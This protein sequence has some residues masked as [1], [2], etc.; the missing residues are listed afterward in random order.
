VAK[1][2]LSLPNGAAWPVRLLIFDFVSATESLD[3][4][5]GVNQLLFAGEERMTVGANVNRYLFSGG[6]GF[7]PVSARARY[8]YIV[9]LGMHVLLQLFHLQNKHG[10]HCRLIRK[11]L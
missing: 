3:T 10:G 6:T 11:S 4:S 1:H 9:V 5:L 7:Y 8:R 2:S